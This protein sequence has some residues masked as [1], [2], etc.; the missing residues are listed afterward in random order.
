[1]NLKQYLKTIPYQQRVELAEKCGTSFAYL[2]KV[3]N[4]FNDSK[5]GEGLAIRIERH[6]NGAVT[7]EEMRPDIDWAF[8]R[9]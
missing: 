2:K 6:T 1:M 7:C 8:L 3:A 9:A 5:P 4:G